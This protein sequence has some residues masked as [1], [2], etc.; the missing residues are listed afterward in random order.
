M[1]SQW[2]CILIQNLYC[3]ILFQHLLQ[4]LR[5][6]HLFL[7]I[8]WNC[9]YQYNTILFLAIS[10]FYIIIKI[11]YNNILLNSTIESPKKTCLFI[12][13]SVFPFLLLIDVLWKPLQYDNFVLILNDYFFFLLCNVPM[14]SHLFH[15]FSKNCIIH[16]LKKFFFKIIFCSFSN[17]YMILAKHFH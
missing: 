2:N 8:Q 7:C 16:Q 6:Y 1:V 12:I 14:L 9:L 11:L 4:Y 15:S 3:Q 17:Q 13:I 5:K 10:G